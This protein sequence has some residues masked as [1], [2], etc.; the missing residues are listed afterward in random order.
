MTGRGTVLGGRYTLTERIGGGGMGAVWR[1][2]DRVLERQVAVKILHAGL[3]EEG[4]F[5]RRFRREAQLLAAISHPGI[6]DVHDYGENDAEGE[7]IAYIVMELVEGR[8]LDKV[9]AEDGAMPAE[10]VLG[11]LATAL[12]ALH[13]AHQQEIVHRDV[14]PSNLMLGA[15]GRV[16]VT[17]FGIARA[18]VST[19]LTATNVVIGTALYMA[20]E[21]AGGGGVT[22]ASDLYSLGVVCYELLTG[23]P[24]FTG[25]SVVEVA[26]KHVQQPAPELP[27]EFAPAVR[28]FVAR[29]L[30]KQPGDRFADAAAMA[31]AARAAVGDRSAPVAAV[32]RPVPP[33]APEAPA[34]GAAGAEVAT[35]GPRTAADSGAG[36]SWR[37]FLVPVVVPVIITTGAATA[38]LV[39][40]SPFQSQ[41]Q[42]PGAQ[43][44]V[45]AP[46]TTA[47][48]PSAATTPPA[49]QTPTTPPASADATPSAP[50]AAQSEAAAAPNTG[51]QS[52]GSA[53]QS[54]GGGAA[55]GG[56][57]S[58][59]GAAGGAASGS[60]GTAP[61]PGGGGGGGSNSGGNAGG[62]GGGGGG[63]STANQPAPPAPVPAPTT[64]A[65]NQ[66]AP[67]QPAPKPSTPTV[68]AGCGGAKWGDIVNV[69][70]GQKL[71]LATGSPTAGAAAVMGGTTAYGWVRSD[72]DPGG[73]YQIYPC[74]LSSPALVQ[75]ADFSNQSSR[76]VMLSSGFGFLNN[77]SVV[78]A[79]TSGVYYLKDYS[80]STCLTDNGAGKQVTMTTCTPGNKYQQ[81][82]IP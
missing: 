4:T 28:E 2:D 46:A 57:G 68:P 77:W 62:G 1:A 44:A 11:M 54:G 63:G 71:G 24:P 52:Q 39:D 81:W 35:V 26:L 51:G 3:L 42:T 74:N 69:A 31:A 9:L 67:N 60:G 32:V 82:Q 75:E 79:G 20:P 53:P 43:P 6:V 16:T 40:R 29:A 72:P 80:G 23:L 18:L 50:A 5:A 13:A 64:Q 36:R 8:P 41:A 22:P 17:D 25:E 19:T 38:L 7:R 55:A 45:S 14:K 58:S 49:S 66:P 56:T 33:P 59:A 30:A 78:G 37:R 12:D 34:A 65:P 76:K 47:G 27:E 10:Q 61:K 21:Q 48:D 15:D 70:D 73:W